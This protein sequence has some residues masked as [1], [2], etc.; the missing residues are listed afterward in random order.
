[1]VK[2]F[3]KIENYHKNWLKKTP[4]QKWQFV[5]DIGNF[6]VE[7][8]GVRLLSDMKFVWLTPVCGLMGLYYFISVIYTIQYYFER[9]KYLKSIECTSIFG[10]ATVVSHIQIYKTIKTAQHFHI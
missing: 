4:K 9:E 2:P 3:V 8:I 7:V 5:Y 6:M 1:M 10:M